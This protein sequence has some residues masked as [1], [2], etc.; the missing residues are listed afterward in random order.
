[1]APDVVARPV[2]SPL[3]SAVGAPT[4]PDGLPDRR[5]RV[6]RA[7]LGVALWGLAALPTVTGAQS[8]SF[9][10]LFHRPCPGC[11]MTRAVDLMLVG[12]WHAS[13]QMHPL[14]VPMLLAGGAF[15]LSTVWTTYLFG[16]PLVHKSILGKVALGALALTYVASIALWV[17]RWF[18][19][20]GGP[21]PV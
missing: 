7:L 18:G 21:V 13:L 3:A 14:A 12:Q 10:K 16:M 2:A 5:T 8:C 4:A 20:Y 1:M 17:L 6:F 9:A 19:Y 11:G 15:A